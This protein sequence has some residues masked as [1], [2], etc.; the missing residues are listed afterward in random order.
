MRNYNHP[1][2]N[3]HAHQ[4]LGWSV[5]EDFRTQYIDKPFEQAAASVGLSPAE[6][7]ALKKQAGDAASKEIVT[8]ITQAVAPKPPAPP[9]IPQTVAQ[10]QTQIT[11]GVKKIQEELAKGNPLYIGGAALAGGLVLYGLYSVVAGPRT[12]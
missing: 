8:Q 9:A 2:M 5:W 1:I 11:S 10:V 3:Q 6:I 4:H 7:E 12:A